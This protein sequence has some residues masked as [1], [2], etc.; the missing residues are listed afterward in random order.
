MT[1][2]QM[3]LFDA[4]TAH[5]NAG[6]TRAA[7]GVAIR[8]TAGRQRMLVLRHLQSVGASGATDQQIQS[9]T[10]LTGNSQRPRRQELQ[11]LEL[12]EDSGDVRP[13][14]AG[15]AAVVWVATAKGLA[16]QTRNEEAAQ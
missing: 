11:T 3:T 8:P 1:S 13:T 12:I 6:I 14:V 2:E 15:R 7:A 5:A 16:I 10:G 4:P 9:A